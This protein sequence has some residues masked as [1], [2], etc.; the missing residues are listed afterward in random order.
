VWVIFHPD[1]YPDK[2]MAP[3]VLGD[4]TEVTFSED[5]FEPVPNDE[6][7]FTLFPSKELLFYCRTV[8]LENGTC[9][10]KVVKIKKVDGGEI[11]PGV[12]VLHRKIFPALFDFYTRKML[13]VVHS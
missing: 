7:E 8:S 1:S 4:C 6:V 11:F 12:K 9:G 5:L 10:L 13:V 3:I 2:N